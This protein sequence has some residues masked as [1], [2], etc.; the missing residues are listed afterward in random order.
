MTD[1]DFPLQLWDE[2]T[3]QVIN[4]LNMMHVSRIDPSKLVY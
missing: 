3:P 1:G 4:T 2:L